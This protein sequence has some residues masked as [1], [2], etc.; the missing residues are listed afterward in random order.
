MGQITKSLQSAGIMCLFAMIYFTMLSETGM[1]NTITRQLI[2]LTR[3]KVNVYMAMILTSLIAG[4]GMMTAT[5]VTSYTIVFPAMMPLYKKMKF[6]CA[7]AMIIAQT[8][9]AGMCF[10]PWGIAVVNSSVFANVDAMELS[11]RLIP[12]AICFI[13]AIVLQWVYFGIQHKRRGL[14]M[15]VEWSDEEGSDEEENPLRRPKLFWINLLIFL[16][17]IAALVTAAVPSYLVFIIASFL[18]IMIDYREPKD[19]QKM[20]N[21]AARCFGGT[22][23]T[24]I[25]ISVFLGSFNE[26]GMVNALVAAG[27]VDLETAFS[28]F[29]NK[30][31]VLIAPI[32]GIVVLTVHSIFAWKLMPKEE[33]IN[34]KALKKGKQT[35]PLTWGQEVYVYVIFAAV[36]VIMLLNRWT[37]DMLYLAPAF[38][39]LALIYGKVLKPSEAARAMTADMVW[40]I[41]GVLIVA[42]ALGRSGA[43]DAIGN[44]VLRLLGGHPSSLLVMFVFSAATVIMTTFLSN[45][46]TQTVLVPIAA[47]IALAG[48]WDPRGVILIIGTANRFAVGFPSGFGEAAV[49]FAAGGYNPVKVMKYTVPYMILSIIVC[50]LTAELM[51]PLY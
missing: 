23:I 31:V 39:V 20:L 46:A 16:A 10:L 28:G 15:V 37:G 36:M 44:L 8:A 49:A 35:E 51:Y 14:P 13:P 27:I 12:V 4:I 33:G 40:M 47:S 26:T 43:G 30:I 50:A 6:D 17:A 22:L 18:T 41:A 7:A 2:K 1:F 45:M 32:P 24:L 3:G 42:D 5:V 38:G 25:R 21:K 19:Y 34:E 48:G 29:G 11:R 9:I